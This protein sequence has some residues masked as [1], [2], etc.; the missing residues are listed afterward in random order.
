MGG[1][2]RDVV[3]AA[4]GGG[5]DFVAASARDDGEGSGGAGLDGFDGDLCDFGVEVEQDLFG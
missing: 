5:G 2:D 3:G 1:V 4:E